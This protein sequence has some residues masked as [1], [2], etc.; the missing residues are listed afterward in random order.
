MIT[1]LCRGVLFGMLWTI[2]LAS[3]IAW[4]QTPAPPKAKLE[5]LGIAAAPVG[6]DTNFTWLNPR[7]GNLDKRPALEFLVGIDRHTGAYIPELAEQWEMAPDGKS[8]TIT[9]R[10]GVKFHDHWGEFTA[11]DVRHSLFLIT[12]PEAVQTDTGLWRTLLGIEQADTIDTVAQK[13]AQM[14]QIV[15]DYQVIIYTHMAAPELVD[16]LSANTDVVME[17]KAH[18]DAGGKELYG[19]KVVGTGPFEFVERSDCGW[20]GALPGQGWVHFGAGI[21]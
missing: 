4:A 7:S 15:H 18:W 16:N 19:K 12:Q 13:V 14:V 20:R 8:W 5:R 21:A 17:S 9:L 10:Q 11:K 1:S 3:T 2:G 6:W